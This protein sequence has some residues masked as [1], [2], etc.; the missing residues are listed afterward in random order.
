[1]HEPVVT[2]SPAASPRDASG[3]RVGEHHDRRERIA[4]EDRFRTAARDLVALSAVLANEDDLETCEVDAGPSRR[5]LRRRRG[6]R[7]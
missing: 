7:C 6:R 5:A 3:R 2:M 1:V 4:V